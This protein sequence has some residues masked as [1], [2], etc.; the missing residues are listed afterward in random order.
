[1]TCYTLTAMSSL[2]L[3][4]INKHVQITISHLSVWQEVSVYKPC[5]PK[6]TGIYYFLT[7]ICDGRKTDYVQCHIR[8][9]L[10]KR[11]MHPKANILALSITL[12]F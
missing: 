3:S 7:E 10:L 5:T 6:K 4:K 2:N 9:R 11:L 8:Y 12:T 1:V